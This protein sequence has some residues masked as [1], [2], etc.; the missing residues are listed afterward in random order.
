MVWLFDV[1]K[2]R[3][4]IHQRD[5]QTENR[6]FEFWR[7]YPRWR[8]SAILDLRGPMMGSLK[9]RCTTSYR[10]SIDTIA[11]NCLVLEKIAVVLH[12]GDR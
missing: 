3:D 2:K 12:F 7:H 6:P 4:K 10:S 9:S 11:L 5:R 1:D 8:I